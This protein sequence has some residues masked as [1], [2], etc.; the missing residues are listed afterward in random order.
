MRRKQG[1]LIESE[2][3]LLLAAVDLKRRGTDRFHGH[4]IAREIQDAT[5][6]RLLLAHGTL[7]KTL[8]RLEDAGL[9]ESEWETPEPTA[10]ESR[11]RRRLYTV[12]VAGE[13]ALASALAAQPRPSRV[14]VARVVPA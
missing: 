7:Y 10:R 14:F 8:A 6:A 11:P 1:T 2:V 9:L 5:G 3:A 12:T 4:L 13:G